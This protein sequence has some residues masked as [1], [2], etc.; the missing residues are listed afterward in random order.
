[1][2]QI[3]VALV[4][5]VKSALT[6]NLG[7]KL[8]SLVAAIIIFSLVHGAEGA[9][10]SI[11]VDVV[12]VLPASD[13]RRVLVSELPDRVKVTLQG[14][15]SL[16]NSIRREELEPVQIDLSDVDSRYYY[17]EPES[18]DFPAGI[19][20]VQLA[21]ASIPLSWS[22]RTERELRVE[23]QLRGAPPSG[24]AVR[25]PVVVEPAHVVVRGAQ[26]A[27]DA[28]AGA[29]TE[30]IALGSFEEGTHERTVRLERLPPHAGYDGS[31]TVRVRFEVIPEMEQLT[32]SGLEIQPVGP[33]A[34]M[35][36]ATVDV[37]LRGPPA[38]MAR[39]DSARIIPWVDTASLV[40]PAGTTASVE[41]SL[42]GIPSEVEVESIE[43]REAL[44][45]L[46]RFFPAQGP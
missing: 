40:G 23:P 1:M 32:L 11:F 37:V 26:T 27:I 18:F 13:A 3:G 20:I 35:V 43:P 41:V 17:F 12:A 33:P 30:P 22:D 10:R 2:R 45:T 28:L 14:S 46:G 8:F 44:V 25:Q 4:E 19:T 31:G 42:R 36:P 5:L 16:L 34:R 39:I 38:A 21:P 7:L 29:R 15:R 9:Q 6:A 24:L